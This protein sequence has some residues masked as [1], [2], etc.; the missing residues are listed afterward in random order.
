MSDEPRY[1]L[2]EARIELNRTE[3]A[4]HG[5]SYEILSAFDSGNPTQL[6]C[7]RCGRS[8]SVLSER[9]TRD[10]GRDAE[11]VETGHHDTE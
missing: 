7:S 3:C 1:T 2:A 5:H 8:W 11:G 10:T 9:Q 4:L 6:L